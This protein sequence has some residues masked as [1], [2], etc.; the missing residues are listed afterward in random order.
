MANIYDQD[1]QPLYELLE[2]AS[3]ANGATILIP[4]LQRPYVWTP[5]Q[6]ILLVDSLIRGWPFG[7]LLMWKV[8][9][10]GLQTIPHR[11]FWEVVDRTVGEDGMPV[12][13]M[14]PPA[15]YQMVLDGQQRLQSLLL[16]LGGDGWGFKME[17][18][19][20]AQ[21]ISDRRPRGRAPRYR[22]WSKAS[23]CFDLWAFAADYAEK[24]NVLAVDY[25]RILQWVITDP[26]QGQ[27][28]WS[29]PQNYEEPLPK[30]VSAPGRYIRLSR[31]WNAAGF[32]GNV[33]ESQFRTKLRPILDQ[34]G[35]PNDRIGGLLAPLAELMTTLCDVKLSKVTYL[36]L[37]PF[38]ADLWDEDGYNDAIVNVFTRLNTAGRTLTREEIT[39]AWLKV[40]WDASQTANKTAGQCFEELLTALNENDLAL[41]IDDLVSAVSLIWS[42]CLKQGKLIDNRD[43]L[44]GPVIRPMALDLSE[45]WNVISNALLDGMEVVT[46]RQLSYGPSGQ[47]ASLNALS[48]VWAWTYLALNW[49]EQTAL[50]VT[51]RDEFSKRWKAAL[52]NY[53]DRWLICSQWAGRWSKSSNKSMAAYA[54]ELS[55]DFAL[56]SK[57][58]SVDDAIRILESRL[59][60]LV[61]DLESEATSF[62]VNL[63]AS[64]RERVALYRTPLWVWH[65][66]DDKRWEMSKIPLRIKPKTKSALDVDHTVAF[67]LWKGRVEKELPSGV[68]NLDD[69]IDVV[70]QLGNCVLLE[71]AFNISKNKQPAKAFLDQI[72]EF[73]SGTLALNDWSTALGLPDA[74]LQPQAETVDAVFKA[75]AVRD[76]LLRDELVDFVKG[77]KSRVDV[78]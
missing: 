50:T 34:E 49:E 53:L 19:A 32:D 14:D 36:E 7:T 25:R 42:V 13:R 71:K 75:I 4:D 59:Q 6:V 57:A 52:H 11:Q 45:R 70:N 39:L 62:V 5:N 23:L 2:K 64:A 8:G 55:D 47:Y 35:V 74:M 67:A 18:R 58:T 33:K 61:T 21:E 56:L 1:S 69:A 10:S 27:S 48:L 38:N 30:A 44:K 9:N 68:D 63:A 31:L 41:D 26:S 24:Q 60:S 76:K 77:K 66:L 40:G 22:H 20:W 46:A 16:A 65:R 73:K 72:H 78:D 37:R 43:L 3:S 12:G 51:L 17:D 54:K 28:S 15:T 29:K